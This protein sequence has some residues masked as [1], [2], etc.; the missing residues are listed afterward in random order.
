MAYGRAMDWLRSL[1]LEALAGRRTGELSGGQAQRVALARALVTE[2]KLLLLDEPLAALDVST[3]SELR[4]VLAEHLSEFAGPRL[5][6]THDPMEAFLLADEICVL[7]DGR[8]SQIG[9]AEE[10]RLSPRTGYAA[11][12]AGANL[13]RGVAADGTVAIDGHE[14]HIAGHDLDGPVLA[15]IHSRAI[16]LHRTM[17]QG[18]PRNTWR[19]RLTRLEHYG[20]RV[21]VQTGGPLALT[22]EVTPDAVH[23]LDLVAGVE[24]WV[25]IKATEIGVQPD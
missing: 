23:A 11:D 19:T 21:R 18:S 4:H 2:P 3:R 6:I 25:S 8:V 1:G 9:T 12:L 24:V 5:L 7:E 22:A 10:I 20:D 15:T 17:P 16:A 14:L 13:L